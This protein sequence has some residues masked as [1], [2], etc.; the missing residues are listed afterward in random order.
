MMLY[1]MTLLIPIIIIGIITY[2]LSVNNLKHESSNMIKMNLDSSAKTVD[3]YL[4]TAQK[5]SMNFLYDETINKLLRPY[6]SISLEQR[7]QLVMIPKIIF[8]NQD[9]VDNFIDSMFVYL[10]DN[11]VY[12]SDG[13]DQFNL[14]FNKYYKFKRY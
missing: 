14:L 1:F 8:R 12:R 2:E 13:I 5:T 10:D 11:K 4:K 9:I 3:I 7:T 6:N